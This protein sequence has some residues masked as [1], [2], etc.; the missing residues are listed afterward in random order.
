M[1]MCNKKVSIFECEHKIHLH[2]NFECS[3]DLDNKIFK[4]NNKNRLVKKA[5]TLIFLEACHISLFLSVSFYF[6]VNFKF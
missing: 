6:N 4:K 2:M 3:S 5:S 1:Q